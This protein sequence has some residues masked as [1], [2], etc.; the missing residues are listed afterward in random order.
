MSKAHTG[1]IATATITFTAD[2]FKAALIKPS[3]TGTYDATTTNY[4]DVTGNSD[5]VTGTGYSAGGAALVNNGL[6]TNTATA[7]ADF[8]DVSWTTASFSVRG[9]EIYNTTQRG[10]V[11]TRATSVHDLGGTQTVTIGTFTLVFPVPDLNNAIL[12][13]A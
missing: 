13:I 8:A 7:Y 10:P 9:V 11:P 12:R 5:E 2:T 6:A 4:T 3:P 1:T